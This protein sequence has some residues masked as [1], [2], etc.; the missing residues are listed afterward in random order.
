M[1]QWWE[2]AC[3]VNKDA[4]LKSYKICNNNNN[5]NNNNE[6]SM[7]LFQKYNKN[8]TLHTEFTGKKVVLW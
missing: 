2:T 1:V 7:I 3:N 4:N 8:I 6:T 5:N